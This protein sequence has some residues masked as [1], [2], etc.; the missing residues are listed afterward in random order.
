MMRLWRAQMTSWQK[1]HWKVWEHYSWEWN[2]LMNKNLMTSN[3]NAAAEKDVMTRDKTLAKIY[4]DFERGLVL[5]GATAVE[6]R[7]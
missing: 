6:D 7:L 4:D 5:I 3:R 1:H 2:Y